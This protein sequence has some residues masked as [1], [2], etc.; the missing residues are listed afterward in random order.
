VIIAGESSYTLMA[1]PARH[2][3]LPPALRLPRDIRAGHVVSTLALSAGLIVVALH[4]GPV[5]AAGADLAD[6]G[7]TDFVAGE[8]GRGEDAVRTRRLLTSLL[9]T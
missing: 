5:M 7:V 4:L 3:E 2:L 6:A 9:G 1:L 8:F